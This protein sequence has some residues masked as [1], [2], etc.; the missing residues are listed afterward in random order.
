VGI[1]KEGRRFAEI[2]EFPEK[3]KAINRLIAR[4]GTI[5]KT[6][7][8]LLSKCLANLL[9]ELN[10]FHPF[11]EGNGRTQRLAMTLLA[12]EKGCLLNLQ[13]P[14]DCHIYEQYMK[15]T[16]EGDLSLL[17]TLINDNMQQIMQKEARNQPNATTKRN[18]TDPRWG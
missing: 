18:D 15:G 3:T 7:K 11:R 5:D 6:N 2:S 4:F 16:I 9:D 17:A 8:P 14:D 1:R 12:K 13:P 10:N